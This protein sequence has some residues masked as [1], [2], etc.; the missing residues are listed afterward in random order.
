MFFGDFSGWKVALTPAPVK[1][2]QME[3]PKPARTFYFTFIF[4][5]KF[6]PNDTSSS[7]LTLF[8]RM[9]IFPTERWEK[10]KKR[11]NQLPE[12]SFGQDIYHKS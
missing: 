12:V 10:R 4:M 11:F 1:A 5:I 9:E 7:R 8:C 3:T 6:E 2:L